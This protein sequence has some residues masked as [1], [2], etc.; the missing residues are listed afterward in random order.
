MSLFPSSAMP[1]DP[2]FSSRSGFSDLPKTLASAL[3]A[4][5]TTCAPNLVLI[6]PRMRGSTTPHRAQQPQ[7]KRLLA[8]APPRLQSS[9]SR[10]VARH[11]PQTICADA[12]T[13]LCP[14]RVLTRIAR[15]ARPIR[16][17]HMLPPHTTSCSPANPSARMQ[18]VEDQT[19]PVTHIQHLPR[20]AV[21]TFNF[22]W[23]V[24]EPILNVPG[25]DV[26][27]G[28]LHHSIGDDIV[29]VTS[30]NQDMVRCV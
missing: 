1:S 10:T 7:T 2:L 17:M 28:S 13:R 4:P 9:P 6:R 14:V 24:N 20:Q 21:Q 26:Q 30:V 8:F 3:D 23:R 29:K 19:R 16:N 15:T 12:S 5:P 25:L 27:L 22:K 18:A 11:A